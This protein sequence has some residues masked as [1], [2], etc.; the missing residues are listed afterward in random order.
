MNLE[1]LNPTWSLGIVFS[2]FGVKVNSVFTFYRP[3]TVCESLRLL[4]D[5]LLATAELAR[6]AHTHIEVK[7]HS[8]FL[9]LSFSLKKHLNKKM[10]LRP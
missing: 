3:K 9:S 6:S 4:R 8:Y 10:S 7:Q 2:V 1:T 5:D